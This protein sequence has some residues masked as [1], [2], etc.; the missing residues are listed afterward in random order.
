MDLLEQ[1]RAAVL[2]WFSIDA[3]AE[4]WERAGLPVVTAEKVAKCMDCKAPNCCNCLGGCTGK[5]PSGRPRL[6]ET[7]LEGQTEIW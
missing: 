1:A 4:E 5:K 6:D 7:P 3:I 2:P